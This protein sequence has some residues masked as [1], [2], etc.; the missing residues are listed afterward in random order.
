[1]RLKSIVAAL[2]ER[3]CEWNGACLTGVMGGEERWESYAETLETSGFMEP[4]VGFEPTTCSLRMSCSTPE[5]Q[6]LNRLI[7]SGLGRRW[8][9]T[10]PLAGRRKV[11]RLNGAD[12]ATGGHREASDWRAVKEYVRG[13]WRIFP[14]AWAQKKSEP[15][16]PLD[17]VAVSCKERRSEVWRAELGDRN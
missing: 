4:L 5:L 11:T 17:S 1:M 2:C 14:D 8:R 6:R 16:G 9:I 7:F 3:R 12:Q 13:E 15:C 10:G